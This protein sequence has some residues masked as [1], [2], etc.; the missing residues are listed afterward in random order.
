MPTNPSYTDRATLIDRYLGRSRVFLNRHHATGF[1]AG[2]VGGVSSINFSPPTGTIEAPRV[3]AV[4]RRGIDAEL[5]PLGFNS[6]IYVR[7]IGERVPLWVPLKPHLMDQTGELFD[8]LHRILYCVGQL[9]AS[10][11]R[12]PY[13]SDKGIHFT[14]TSMSSDF[15]RRST[16]PVSIHLLLRRPNPSIC[17]P[18]DGELACHYSCWT[19]IT[20]YRRTSVWPHYAPA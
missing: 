15:H 5:R 6:P 20:L 8:T 9:V 10:G 3:V 19:K 2:Y 16:Q 12:I 18:T 13:L 7:R 17:I 11:E 1:S 14:G 4:M